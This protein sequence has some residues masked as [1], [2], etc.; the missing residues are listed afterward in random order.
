MWS[1]CVKSWPVGQL[2]VICAPAG[3]GK[4][5]LAKRLART[6]PNVC[7][8]PT[9]T[10]RPKRPNEEPGNDYIF[11]TKDDFEGM[12]HRH[13]LLEHIELHGYWYGTSK[14]EVDA[15]RS[16]GKHAIL[17]IDTRG[18]LAIRK[19]LSCVL[20]FITPPSIETLRQRL[21]GRATEDSETIDKRLAWAERELADEQYFDYSVMNEDVDLAFQVLSGIIAAESHRVM[22]M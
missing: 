5:T 4:T 1:K 11:V 17:V 7:S 18:A 19:L 8:V 20:I 22:R 6:L 21:E 2:F 15:V 16:A 12:L 13:E 9:V 3:A 14:R 10:T